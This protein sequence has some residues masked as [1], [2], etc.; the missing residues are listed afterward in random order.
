MHLPK[1]A[2]A[3]N[4]LWSLYLHHG[5]FAQASRNIRYSMDFNDAIRI[6]RCI[7]SM[8]V[9]VRDMRHNFGRGVASLSL[10]IDDN[11][12]KMEDRLWLPPLSICEALKA[13]KILIN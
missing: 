6:D 11:K 12:S 1:G 7:K 9:E 3:E 8:L 13:E 10:C 5:Y 4:T 2:A